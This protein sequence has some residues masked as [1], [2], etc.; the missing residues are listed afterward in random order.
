MGSKTAPKQ[1]P[2]MISGPPLTVEE[3]PIGRLVE[4]SNNPR[5]NDGAV[6]RMCNAI[7]EFGFRIPVVARSSGEV[8][9]GHLRLKAARVLGLKTVPVVLADDLTE[10]Q[11]KAF[12]ILVNQSTNWANWDHEKLKVEI[13][14]LKVAQFDL[15]VLGFGD[16]QLVDFMTGVPGKK[17][18][19][20]PAEPP[21]VP[22]IVT[23]HGDGWLLG[24]HILVVGKAGDLAADE[25]IRRWQDFTKGSALL[26]DDGRTF[27]EV[28]KER[29]AVPAKN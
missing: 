15:P 17:D 25:V 7:R 4:Y 19:K 21:P 28:A 1:P 14:D 6:E 29:V 12:R 26:E 5:D 13:G 11:V 16:L 24:S 22:A 27:D 9:D 3:W 10:T 18:R 2:V 8:V 23:R 20:A